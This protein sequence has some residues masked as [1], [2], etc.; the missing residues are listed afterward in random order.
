M[1][2]QE[3]CYMFRWHLNQDVY[4]SDKIHR[5]SQ[6]FKWLLSLNN[7]FAAGALDN[8]LWL[9]SDKI[10]EAKALRK[11]HIDQMTVFQRSRKRK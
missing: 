5:L 10:D 8:T 11:H 9:L 1:T 2:E 3:R 6:E 4:Y 7:G